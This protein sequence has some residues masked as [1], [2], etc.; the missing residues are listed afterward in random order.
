M[1][2]A[3]LAE[4]MRQRGINMRYLGK[5]LDLVLRSPARDQLDHIYVS[6]AWPG[7][8][9]QLEAWNLPETYFFDSPEN[10]HWRAH[11]ALRQAHLQDL[12]AGAP[13][14]PSL[15][16]PP[17][18]AWGLEKSSGWGLKAILTSTK[19]WL[20]EWSSQ[21]SQLPSATS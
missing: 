11:H 20:R 16:G 19:T 2:G 12:P 18:V 13:L 8:R 3:T 9:W 4:V 21:A 15:V 6:G 1:D 7:R 17:W 10:R 14:L 5:V